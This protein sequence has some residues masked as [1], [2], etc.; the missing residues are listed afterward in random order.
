MAD[1]NLGTAWLQVSLS[2]QG[3]SK[4]IRR[5]LGDVDTGPLSNKIKSTVG[6]A[7]RTVGAIGGAA[8]AVAG[9]ALASYSGEVLK[10][11]DSAQKFS[12]TL[13]FAGIGT[14]KIK[15]LTAST[16]QYA[17]QTVYDIGDIRQTTAALAANGVAD[18]DKLAQAAGNLNA[19]AGGSAETYK[20]VGSVMAQTAGAGKLVTENWNQIRDAVPSASKSIKDA[21]AQSG[22]YVGDFNTAMEK[23]E[24]TA[25]EFNDAIMKLGFE[26]A[27]V[28]AAASTATFEGAW[29]NFQ[30]T[31]VD[32]LADIIE[33]LK[34][35]LTGALGAASESLGNFFAGAA[36]M[37]K[38]VRSIFA[39]GDF[40]GFEHLNISE[41]SPVVDMLF[42]IKENAQAVQGAIGPIAGTLAGMLGPL[43]SG[44]PF[45]GGLFTGLTGP[46]GLVIGLFGQMFANSSQLRAALTDLA[47]HVMNAFAAFGPAI[48]AVLP[49]IGS[50]AGGLGDQ[51]APIIQMLGPLIEQ[52]A[53]TLGTALVPIIGAVGQVIQALFPVL[54]SVISAVVEIVQ[55]V[56]PSFLPVVTMAGETFGMLV[57]AIA[58]VVEIIGEILTPIIEA[59]APVVTTVFEG[60]AAVITAAMQYIQGIIKTVTAIMS[61]DWAGAWEGMK[62]AA[63]ALWGLIGAAIE[64][65]INIVKSV[66]S[67]TLRAIQGIWDAIWTRIG[68]GVTAAWEGIK[69]SISSGVDSA[70]NTVVGIKDRIVGFFS[71]AGSWLWDA[72]S[73][74]I[75]GLVDGLY[76]GFEW[77][78]ST[79]GE[80]TAMLPDWKGPAE[81]DRV[82]LRDSGRLVMGGFREG[83]EDE[84][85]SIEKT[86][87]NFTRGLI[88]TP[89]V[90]VDYRNT[91]AN[92]A[93]KPSIVV[94]Q[95][96]AV[97]NV[98]DASDL[99]SRAAEEHR[100]IGVI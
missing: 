3:I 36:D 91:N 83:L 20:T 69:S 23:G 14:D 39:D 90:N 34:G 75:S 60:A 65:A 17:A 7:F 72:G 68:D 85:G 29:G 76:S 64:A 15:E 71:G 2:G 79:L 67:S 11:S 57:S 6:N 61:G 52:V 10:A 95:H 93:G 22:A 63:A 16:K 89:P 97:A 62:Q 27:A 4:Q 1:H 53:S 58:P 40:L 54:S 96:I 24:I 33:P 73:S 19:V 45:I 38:N 70:Y 30:A 88:S 66:I 42:D 18:Y 32:G 37:V 56:L 28:K 35:D 77:V 47:G 99:A 46:V 13:E 25:E 59:L 50:L 84:Y 100:L 48:G 98:P 43:L 21:L 51:I 87:G 44:L 55:A 94:N 78:R 26:D 9:A 31:I 5:E 8:L 80:L 41:D 86:L 12:S 82:I 49:V 74:I 81:L 92:V